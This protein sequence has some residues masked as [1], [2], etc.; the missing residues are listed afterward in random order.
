M[1]V[2]LSTLGGL[3]ARGS[4]QAAVIAAYWWLEEEGPSSAI[5]CQTCDEAGRSSKLHFKLDSILL[6]SSCSAPH[7]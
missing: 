1:L 2:Q 4:W 3:E 7:A 5:L 6:L